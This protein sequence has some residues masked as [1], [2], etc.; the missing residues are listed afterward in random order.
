[1]NININLLKLMVK[2]YKKILLKGEDD[3]QIYS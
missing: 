2:R 1:M 3:V